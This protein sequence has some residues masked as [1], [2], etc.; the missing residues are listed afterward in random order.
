MLGY[1]TVMDCVK[2]N[3]AQDTEEQKRALFDLGSTW[4][5]DLRNQDDMTIVVVE[6]NDVFLV[7][8][9]LSQ[10]LICIPNHLSI[11]LS[12]LL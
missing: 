2:A 4:L 9:F 11:R 10:F 5:Q 8:S 3:G 12:N 1:E 6:K 7:V